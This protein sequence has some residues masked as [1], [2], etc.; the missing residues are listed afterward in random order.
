MR[1]FENH[2]QWSAVKEVSNRLTQ[3]GYRVL[4]A[5][6]CVRDFIMKKSAPNDF[7][8]ATDATPEQVEVLFPN[9]LMVG[10]AF[11][12][13]II[14]FQ[15]FQL[16]VATF[17]EDLEYKDGRRPEGVLFSSPEADA[18]RRDFTVNAL[19]YDLN[20]DKVIDYVGGATD[21]KRRVLRTVGDPEKRFDED[22]LR[23]LRAVRF[24]AQLD[25]DIEPATLQTVKDKAPDITVVSRERIRDELVKLLKTEKRVRGLELLIETGLL[26]ALF[27]DLFE[28]VAKRKKEWHDWF[29]ASA[30]RENGLLSLALFF[31]PV[32]GLQSEKEFRE[33]YL[34]GLRLENREIEAIG[35]ALR[36]LKSLLRPTSLREGELILLLAQPA[37]SLALELSKVV[38]RDDSDAK[39]RHDFLSALIGSRLP[40]IGEK[41]APFLVGADATAVGFSPGP[42]L[43]EV[44]HEAY[45]LQL[46]GKFKNRDGALAW[47]R[48]QAA[49]TP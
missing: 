37:A 21:I 44:L 40:K 13:S 2:K 46:E 6:G 35:F 10:R 4:L 1:E 8:I 48:T 43:G 38:G 23:I 18:K 29:A 36:S 31:L 22:K 47:L 11:G 3:A 33:T 25:F 20:A 39:E 24:A 12:V 14:P 42:Y 49:K 5:G 7:D 15:D 41:P 17:R 28:Q 45:L 30:D 32:Y 19:F 34:R 27:P 9:A 16:E 26:K